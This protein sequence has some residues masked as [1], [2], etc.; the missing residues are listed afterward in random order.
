MLTESLGRDNADTLA[1]GA[2]LVVSLRTIGDAAAAATLNG[3]VVTRTARLLGS[4]HPQTVAARQG[5]RIS[6]DISLPPP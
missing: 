3:E 5:V 6:C 1:V 4:E 2:N